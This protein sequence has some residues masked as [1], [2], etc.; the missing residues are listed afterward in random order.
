M[1]ENYT[2]DTFGIIHQMVWKPKIYDREYLSYYEGL[3]ERTIKLGYR[4][5]GWVLGRLGRLPTS[6]LEIGYGMGTFLEAAALAGVP[7]C[8]GY[9]V[10]RYPLPVRCAFI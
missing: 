7:E 5:L 10:A 4:R 3:H 2:Q 8:A 1:L 6:V 9:D